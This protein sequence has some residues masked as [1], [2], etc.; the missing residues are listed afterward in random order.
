MNQDI[1]IMT[2]DINILTCKWEFINI[3][4]IIG[5]PLSRIQHDS[6]WVIVDSITKFSRFL[7]VNTTNSSEDYATLYISEIVRLYGILLSIFSDR[8]PRFTSHILKSFQKGLG[9]QV[10]LTTTFH[11]QTDEHAER[12][13]KT[14]ED[15]LR[16]CVI[17]FSGSL[18]DHLTLIEF[19]YNNIYYSNIQMA[20]FEALCGH[21]CR[22][23][24]GWF[25][26]Y[27]AS[28]KDMIQSFM[29]WRK[30]NSL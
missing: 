17:E 16:S 4:F 26:V 27:E 15:I 25:E 29:L 2:Q 18:N 14:L 12:T 8:S 24:V 19:A 10:N 1:H 20:P 28:L 13:I 11:P 5:L 9:T 30:C 21:R 3:Y 6:I 22:S 7:A 23:L